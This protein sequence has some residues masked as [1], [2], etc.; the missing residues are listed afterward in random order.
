M[1]SGNLFARLRDVFAPALAPGV[2]GNEGRNAFGLPTDVRR[3]DRAGEASVP[4][5]VEGVRHVHVANL[6]LGPLVCSSLA[7][8]PEFAEPCASAK[9]RLWQPLQRW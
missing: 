8:L 9:S 4:D 7:K 1:A 5:G 2:P 3:H 6:K